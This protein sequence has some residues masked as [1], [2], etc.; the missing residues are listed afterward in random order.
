[1]PFDK[2]ASLVLVV[3]A[4]LPMVPL[5]GTPIPLA[6]IMKALGEFLV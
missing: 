6:E 5:L 3:A 4:V 2:K 1:M